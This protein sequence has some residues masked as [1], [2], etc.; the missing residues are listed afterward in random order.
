MISMAH[1]E[2][3]PA[4]EAYLREVAETAAAKRA[5]APNASV[6]RE[7]GLVER[8]SSLVERMFVAVGELE[9]AVSHLDETAD[10][11]ERS[12]R[13]RDE[14]LPAMEALRA[15]ADEAEAITAKGFWPFPTYGD[16]LFGVR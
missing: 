5:V 8:L 1:A 2:I 13:I 7:V 15:P 6:E 4:V 14:V 3:I 16:L 11:T 10:V 9:E 12:E